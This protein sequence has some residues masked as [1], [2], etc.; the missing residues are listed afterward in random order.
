MISTAFTNSAS[1]RVFPTDHQGVHQ[2]VEGDSVTKRSSGAWGNRG[3]KSRRR[4]RLPILTV[5]QE[6]CRTSCHRVK[7]SSHNSRSSWLLSSRLNRPRNDREISIP[8]IC[9]NLSGIVWALQEFVGRC[10]FHFSHWRGLAQIIG[11]FCTHIHHGASLHMA[12][13]APR[14]F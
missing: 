8:H 12:F 2:K 13:W 5:T 1:N 4:V 14:C 9:I 10:I 6:T 7:T 11:H 3:L